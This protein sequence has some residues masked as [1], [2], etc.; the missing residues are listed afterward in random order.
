MISAQL[1]VPPHILK[2]RPYEP[3]LSP[4]QVKERY[5]IARA[6]K[7]ASN[8]NPLGASPLAIENA[9]RALKDMFLYPD[10]GLALRRK[11]AERYNLKP[12]N[13]IAGAGSEG[14]MANIVRAFLGDEDEVLTTEAAFSGFQVLARSRGV[15][16]RTVSYLDWR[17]DLAKMADAI[18]DRTK[19]I[20]LAN[21]NNPTGTFFT[22]QEFEEFHRRV[23]ERVLIILDEAYFEFAM[24]EPS[25]PDSMQYRFDNVITLRTFSKIYGLAGAR[26]GYGFAHQD[27]ISV[28]L[29]IKLPFE[30]SGIGEA[31]ALGALDDREFMEQSIANNVRGLAFMT[32]AFEALGFTV[33]PSAANFIMVVLD[34]EELAQQLFET[35]LRRGVIVRPLKASGLANCL[36]VSIG[37]QDE[38][39][40]CIQALKHAGA[41]LEVNRYATTN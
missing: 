19:L 33:V 27:L 1:L 22:R 9:K 37:T 26:V 20:Y 10:G 18:T 25:Y 5:G 15:A 32:R 39:E 17:Y 21:P 23:P 40:M 13:V 36:R 7:L 8:E 31:A 3:G 2:L 30:P 35:L 41:E 14:I 28:L 29:K 34:T 24:S 4:E 16:Y 12:E 6:I 11:L 38:N